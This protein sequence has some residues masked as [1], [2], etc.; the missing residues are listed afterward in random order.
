MVALLFDPKKSYHEVGFGSG[1]GSRVAGR[2]WMSL[3]GE[4]RVAGCVRGVVIWSDKGGRIA[5]YSLNP[6]T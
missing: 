6:D 1:R 2:A 4:P 3:P 5:R